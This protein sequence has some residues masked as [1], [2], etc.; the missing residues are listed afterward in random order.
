MWLSI[1]AL[2]QTQTAPTRVTSLTGNIKIHEGFASKALGNSRTISVY[3]PPGYDDAKSRQYPVLYMHDG[4]NVFD[5]MRSF[6]PNQ[7]WKA[8]ESAESMINAK[9]IEPI[10][11]V[12]IDNG[13]MKRADEFLPTAAKMGS[14][15]SGGNA[16]AY[17]K[18]LVEE[19]KP[20]IDKTYRTQTD[21]AHTALCGSS[22]GGIVTLHLGLTYPDVFG[23]LGICSPSVWWDHKVVLKEVE[24]LAKHARQRV[25]IDAGTGEGGGM[26]TDAKLLAAE[27]EK[28][29]WTQGKDLILW[30]DA[31]AQHN[32]AAWA[33]RL[34]SI[35]TYFF[36]R[37]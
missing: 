24:Q 22:F 18:M 21:A 15:T 23:K 16:N 27:F 32:E 26:D 34:P 6:I 8:D 35:L 13:G 3:L 7:E 5:G 12:A 36:A 4:Q 29:G 17:G 37:H 30:I 28:K 31:H 9:L 10:I 2:A 11:I 20:F 14:N 19:I 1:L 33:R 25:W